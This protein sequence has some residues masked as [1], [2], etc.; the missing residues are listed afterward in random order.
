MAAEQPPSEADYSRAF[1]LLAEGGGLTESE[2]LLTRLCRRSFL[3]LWAFPNLHTDEGFK[4]G[5]G[6]A[7]ELTDVL[8]LF[9]DDVFFSLTSTCQAV[10]LARV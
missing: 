7:K 6:A 3:S 10:S 8:L 4:Q 5:R 1:H 2:R 9:G